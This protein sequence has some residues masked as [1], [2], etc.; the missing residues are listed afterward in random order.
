[1]IRKYKLILYW[2]VILLTYQTGKSQESNNIHT[3]DKSVG[4]DTHNPSAYGGESDKNQ[5]KICIF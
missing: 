5:E 4:K 1:M 3:I 2:D